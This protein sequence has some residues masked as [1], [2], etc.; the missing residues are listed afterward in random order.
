MQHIASAYRRL[1]DTVQQQAAEVAQRLGDGALPRVALLTPGPYSETYFEHA[2][3]A[4]Y[5]GVRWSKAPT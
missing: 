2:Y 5:L 1:L 4:R 3:L